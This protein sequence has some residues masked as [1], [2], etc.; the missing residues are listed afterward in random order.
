MS[1][2]DLLIDI[3]YYLDKSSKRIQKLRD[4]QQMCDVEV[5]KILKHVCTR[6]LSLGLCINRLLEQWNPLLKYFESQQKKPKLASKTQQTATSSSGV[7]STHKADL[8]QKEAGTSSVTE[9]YAECDI[10]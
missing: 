6:W 9:M 8:K 7:A 1:I 4:F 5:R 3:Y 2:D 10:S